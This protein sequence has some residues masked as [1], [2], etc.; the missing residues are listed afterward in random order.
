VATARA[1]SWRWSF[2]ADRRQH[3][4][5]RTPLDGLRR[6]GM[7]RRMA[8]PESSTPRTAAP[9][10]VAQ[11]VV[12]FLTLFTTGRQPWLGVPRTRD[13][14]L[15]VLRAW[16][17]ERSG[18]ILAVQAMPDHVHVLLESGRGTDVAQVV[19]R[20]RAAVRRGA[21]YAQTFENKFRDHSLGP[22]ESAED[23][24]QYMFM[25][26]YRQGLVKENESWAGWWLPEGSTLIFTA[27][28]IGR[29]VPPKEWLAWPADK[30]ARVAHGE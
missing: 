9:A 2:D 27:A 7:M 30:F 16:H 6:V 14:F 19:S 13:V 18:R 10:P 28:L 25:D 26:P 17:M 11:P 22:A 20:W 24:A 3:A 5:G 12:R 8:S 23:Y 4:F 29:G 15:A 21:G 1:S